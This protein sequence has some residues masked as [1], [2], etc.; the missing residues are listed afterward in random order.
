M[1][2]PREPT[3]SLTDWLDFHVSWIEERAPQMPP[4][5]PLPPLM[6]YQLEGQPSVT[7]IGEWTTP[8]ACVAALEAFRSMLIASRADRYAYI[9]RIWLA[10]GRAEEP[11]RFPGVMIVVGDRER[12]ISK[13]LAL[14]RD[15]DGRIT[16]VER[17]AVPPNPKLA[18]A[19]WWDLLVPRTVQ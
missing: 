8:E 9:D 11:D 5:M 2:M 10:D 18:Q 15:P 6:V 3:D 7:V 16:K 13:I 12:S 19:P 17:E 4:K 14:T 1:A